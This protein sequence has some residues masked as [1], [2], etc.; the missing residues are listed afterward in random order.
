VDIIVVRMFLGTVTPLPSHD[1]EP[2]QPTSTATRFLYH[3]HEGHT[4]WGRLEA[5]HRA[6]TLREGAESFHAEARPLR[7]FDFDFFF[8]GTATALSSRIRHVRYGAAKA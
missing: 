3:P 2:A 6:H 1:D 7:V 5:P 4:V 8:L